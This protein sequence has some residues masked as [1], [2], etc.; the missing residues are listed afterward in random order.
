LAERP[1]VDFHVRLS[2]F[3]LNFPCDSLISGPIATGLG[4][5]PDELKFLSRLGSR[6]LLPFN[7]LEEIFSLNICQPAK[8]WPQ[9]EGIFHP[10]SVGCWEL[11]PK[12][13]VGWVGRTSQ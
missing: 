1:T 8:S 6:Y 7:G 9:E 5:R 2:L 13:L 4:C 10:P 11:F 12:N 3:L